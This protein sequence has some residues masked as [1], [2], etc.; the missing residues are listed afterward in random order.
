MEQSNEDLILTLKLFS[1]QIVRQHSLIEKLSQ[2]IAE[3]QM[4]NI[5]MN[6]FVLSM[7]KEVDS[8]LNK[9]DN[10]KSEKEIIST[11]LSKVEPEINNIHEKLDTI[12]ESIHSKQKLEIRNI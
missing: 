12:I 8:K 1:D 2:E 5:T 7:L 4:Q 11:F 9:I 6:T 10:D 3:V